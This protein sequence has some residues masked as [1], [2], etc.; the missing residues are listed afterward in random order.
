M[1]SILNLC[2]FNYLF[3]EF[4]I[5]SKSILK[6]VNPFQKLHSVKNIFHVFNTKASVLS[7]LKQ[8]FSIFIFYNNINTSFAPT[9]WKL[10]TL[11]CL[12][13]IKVFPNIYFI[14][15]YKWFRKC[16]ISTYVKE[17]QKFIVQ[18]FCKVKI[19]QFSALK[20]LVPW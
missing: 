5:Y 7:Q 1:E 2:I 17:K 9:Q 16:T 19:F 8:R 6:P 12:Y 15:S 10:N 11:K 4:L 3:Q 18:Y 13:F 20:H 14:N